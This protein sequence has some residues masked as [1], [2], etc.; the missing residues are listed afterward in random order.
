VCDPRGRRT[1]SAH[2]VLSR[3]G[4]NGNR[5][6]IHIYTRALTYIGSVVDTML[7]FFKRS[8]TATTSPLSYGRSGLY[9]PTDRHFSI[10]DPNHRH[11]RSVPLPRIFPRRDSSHITHL[12]PPHETSRVLLHF[13]ILTLFL[14]RPRVSIG[15]SRYIILLA[16]SRDV[17]AACVVPAR[18]IY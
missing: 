1:R 8:P 15:I 13:H 10:P 3:C 9:N 6:C 16:I 14:N 11:R 4:A 12:P 2:I 17:A 5:R 7:E 18:F